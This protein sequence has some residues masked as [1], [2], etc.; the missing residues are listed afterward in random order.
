MGMLLRSSDALGAAIRQRRRALGLNQMQLA[1]QIG[2]S[3]QWVIAME[4]GKDSAEV[5]LL[6]RALAAL[7][8][9]LE[10]APLKTRGSS[11]IPEID[12]DAIVQRARHKEKAR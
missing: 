7:G 4:K 2:V 9:A 6:L 5:G 10:L 1:E 8:L 11:R 12:I 3:R